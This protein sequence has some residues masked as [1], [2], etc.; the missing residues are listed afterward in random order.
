M[1]FENMNFKQ[2]WTYSKAHQAVV[3]SKN[4]DFV[5]NNFK[6]VYNDKNKQYTNEMRYKQKNLKSQEEFEREQVK[7]EAKKA[8]LRQVF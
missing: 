6:Q 1:N 7:Y 8:Q 5:G 4:S 2:D 3:F